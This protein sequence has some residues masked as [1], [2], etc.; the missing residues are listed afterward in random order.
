MNYSQEMWEQ[1]QQQYLRPVA[2]ESTNVR[3]AFMGKVYGILTVGLL[4]AGASCLITMTSPALLGATVKIM[5]TW[6]LY[7]LLVFGLTFGV[8]AISRI[9]VLNVVG[10]GLYTAFFGAITAPIVLMATKSAGGPLV[11][12]Q[13]LGLTGILFVGLTAWALTTKDDLSR[14]GTYLFIGALVLAGV[15]I[16]GALTGF[17]VGLWYS[18]LWVALLAGYVMY[19]TQMIQRRYAVTDVIPAG[20]AL[21]TDFIIMFWHIL[22]LLSRRD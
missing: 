14:W 9:P 19:D 5:S 21:F 4:L 13:A 12:G 22:S 15:G 7:L 17:N 1:A 8:M 18:A 16:V 11:V 20:I 6:W 2:M 10:Y 3:S